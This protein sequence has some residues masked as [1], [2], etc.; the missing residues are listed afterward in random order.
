MV[1]L[2]THYPPPADDFRDQE[3]PGPALS[4]SSE[5]DE[6]SESTVSMESST[7]DV[8]PLDSPK[9]RRITKLRGHPCAAGC[10]HFCWA[11]SRRVDEF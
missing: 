5:A 11:A 10:G 6:D 3:L 1:D 2:P 8:P 4:A 7:V 9:V